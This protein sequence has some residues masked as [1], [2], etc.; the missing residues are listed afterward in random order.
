MCTFVEIY[1]NIFLVYLKSILPKQEKK[2]FQQ[3]NQN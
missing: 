1:G 2:D 3:E